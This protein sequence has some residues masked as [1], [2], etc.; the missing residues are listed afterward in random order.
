MPRGLS[1]AKKKNNKLKL[2]VIG[3]GGREHALVWK[4]SQS[5]LVEKIF[6]APGNAGIAQLASC[7]DISATNIEA[8]KRFA[9]ENVIDLTVVGPEAALVAGIV[10]E[11][12]AHGLKIFGPSRL[13]AMIEGSKAYAK[14]LMKKYHI[15][16]ADFLIF[17][18]IQ[19][20]RACLN[21]AKL[22]AVIKADGLAAGKGV[23]VARSRQE[24]LAT[25][26]R[27]MAQ[28]EF[29]K[30]G[31]K[32]VVEEFMQGEEVSILALTDG[33]S[34]RV[35]PPA[36][37][38][39]AIFED[40]KGPNTGGMGAYSPA[41]VV[42]PDLMQDIRRQILE[43]TIQALASEG[44]PYR[45]VLYA[46]LMITVD[47]PKVVEFNCRFGDPETQAIVPLIES[48]L[49]EAL[50]RVA[51]GR[52]EGYELRIS[53]RWAVG[54]VMA[55]GGYPGKYENGKIVHGLDGAGSDDVM[56][57]HAGTM[58]DSQRRILTNGGR[59]L[60]VTGIGDSFATARA[61][62]YRA[63]GKIAFDG[64][65]FRKDIGARA[66]RHLTE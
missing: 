62:A 20:A 61:R 57:F 23:V 21:D 64:A 47:G 31:A 25:L 42:K 1:R 3:S 36:Q 28:K 49:A 16:T 54:V 46:G 55:S 33:A 48:D 34:L 66:Q 35:L 18:D 6:C 37:D 5:P 32:V 58:L 60:A 39:K 17:E 4:L 29:G 53:S 15:P 26:E 7:L 41:P 52:L 12:E 51:N 56:I 2:L 59:V 65:H 27:M 19:K 13:A 38:H 22:P 44:R 43:P 45:G 30:A 24:A 50:W 63:V 14:Q 9:V 10:D 11:F 8:L 40:D